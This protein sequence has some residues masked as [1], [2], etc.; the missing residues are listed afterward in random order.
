MAVH[1]HLQ[2]LL[3]I[4]LQLTCA[5]ALTLPPLTG[6]T[7]VAANGTGPLNSEFYCARGSRLSRRRPRFADCA[8]A[9]RQLRDNHIDGEF[10]RKGTMNQWQLPVVKS[11]RTCAVMVD[12]KDGIVNEMGTWLGVSLAAT[13]LNMVCVGTSMFPEYQGGYTTAGMYDGVKVQLMYV[14]PDGPVGVG[15]GTGDGD[16][17]VS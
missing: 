15:N 5:L 7:W 6:S 17:G 9:I 8:G 10:H 16:L 2:L 14:P 3:A 1:R 4:C 12:M 13:Q 11:H